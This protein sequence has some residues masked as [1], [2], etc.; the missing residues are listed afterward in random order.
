MLALVKNKVRHQSLFEA[1]LLENHLAAGTGSSHGIWGAITKWLSPYGTCLFYLPV[2]GPPS[3]KPLLFPA[4]GYPAPSGSIT[5]FAML[6]PGGAIVAEPR[7]TTR[8]MIKLS[9]RIQT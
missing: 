3:V 8:D 2:W 9:N 7:W 4:S 6:E 5:T 1:P